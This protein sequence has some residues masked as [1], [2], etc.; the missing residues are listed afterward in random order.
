MPQPIIMLFRIAYEKRGIL[1][2]GIRWDK[3]RTGKRW[4][5]DKAGIDSKRNLYWRGTKNGVDE[6]IEWEV[7]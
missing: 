2:L 4:R 1:F 6:M 5:N 3:R 7:W